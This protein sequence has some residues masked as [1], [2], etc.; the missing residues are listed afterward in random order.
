MSVRQESRLPTARAADLPRP[1]G[2]AAA[3]SAA[4]SRLVERF[5]LFQIACQLALILPIGGGRTL[6][7]IASLGVS[8]VLLLL[9]RGRGPS[10]PSRGPALVVLAIVFISTLHP[11][12]N[13]LLAA[14]VQAAM[15]LAILAPLFW[16]VRLRMDLPALHRSLLILWGFQSL[17]ALVGVLQVYFP[18]SLQ[19][20][21]SSVILAQ[22]PGYV[23]SLKIVTASGA[24]VFRPM[25]LTDV[26]GGAGGAGFYAVLLGMGFFLNARRPATMAVAVTSM[27]TGMTALYLS[28][29]R[30]LMA[31]TII[32]IVAVGGFLL[33][34]RDVWRAAALGTVLL[35]VLLA[36]YRGAVL[37]GGGGI[38]RRIATLTSAS[39][40]QVYS[41]NRGAF[42]QQTLEEFLPKYP[43]GAGMGRWGMMNSYF[44][45]NSN[46]TTAAIYVEI[47]WT[48]W[49][50]DGGIP[51]ILA[52]L[53][54]IGVALW[55]TWKIAQRRAPPGAEEL[56]FWSA[57]LFAYGIGALALTFSYPVFLSQT[58]ME[59]WLLNAALFT[60]ARTHLSP[61]S[62]AWHG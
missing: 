51:L 7:R 9:V 29:V 48:G 16:V 24:R 62:P 61:P 33:V 40:G 39:P 14:T 56:R 15:Y 47:Q 27:L 49:L 23:E 35:L 21:V 8:L 42:L 52:Y 5:I 26:P 41:D 60:A 45:D 4:A 12:S 57:I 13:T 3:G 2:V 46:P 32:G 30:A 59:F 44:G 38:A 50:L 55:T 43:L 17:S 19:P 54:T 25:G 22:G 20:N 10:H 1:A 58:G 53:A 34:R 18:G 31:M 28:H 11:T 37:M 36:G 6:V